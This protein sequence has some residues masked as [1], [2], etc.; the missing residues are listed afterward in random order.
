MG[1][2]T[3]DDKVIT[4]SRTAGSDTINKLP[5]VF[6]MQLKSLF[7]AAISRFLNLP[8]GKSWIDSFR[9]VST[10]IHRGFS[11]AMFDYRRLF[12][13]KLYRTSNIHQHP[14]S[15]KHH[16]IPLWW[17][18]ISTFFPP[19]PPSPPHLLRLRHIPRPPHR[20]PSPPGARLL[21]L[22]R[23]RRLRIRKKT[24]AVAMTHFGSYPLVN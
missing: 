20:L 23:H 14:Q 1:I 2:F 18:I 21:P 8:S 24:M 11:L 3:I 17:S 13:T 12:N 16:E 19:M 5:G 10:F 6:S 22:L 15:Q 9:W 4:A 7:A